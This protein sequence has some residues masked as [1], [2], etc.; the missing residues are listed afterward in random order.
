MVERSTPPGLSERGG[1]TAVTAG[2]GAL[3]LFSTSIID[4]SHGASVIAFANS[5]GYGWTA[6]AVLKIYNWTGNLSGGGSDQLYFMNDFGLGL[7][8]QQLNQ[9]RFFSDSGSTFLGTAGWANGMTGEIVPVPEPGTWAAGALLTSALGW[10]NR[11]RVKDAAR[12]AGRA[13][14]VFGA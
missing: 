10:A 12:R 2:I 14:G 13:I 5:S 1:T 7:T 9:I 6:D 8:N 4:L 3:T 11:R